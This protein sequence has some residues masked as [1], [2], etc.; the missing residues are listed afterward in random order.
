[1]SGR[2]IKRTLRDAYLFESLGEVRALTERW[3]VTY[4]QERPHESLGRVPPLMFLPR[5]NTPVQS[6]FTVST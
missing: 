1:M 6:P 5:P 4:N 2:P 3:L